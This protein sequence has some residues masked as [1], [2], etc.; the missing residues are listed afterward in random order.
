VRPGPTGCSP[1]SVPLRTETTETGIETR[2]KTWRQA[3]PA[4]DGVRSR[5][6]ARPS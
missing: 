1:A 2:P 6:V 3:E 4:P 5:S